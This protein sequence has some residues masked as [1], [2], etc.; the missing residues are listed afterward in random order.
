MTSTERI[1]LSEAHF[2]LGLLP[3]YV[4]RRAF[5]GYAVFGDPR[6]KCN[7]VRRSTTHRPSDAVIRN[8]QRVIDAVRNDFPR[9]AA[10]VTEFQVMRQIER[11]VENGRE[12]ELI[13]AVNAAKA[14]GFDRMAIAELAGNFAIQF[15]QMMRAIEMRKRT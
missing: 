11:A 6:I 14:A 13:A 10:R 4:S 3:E 15:R 12:K 2:A 8:S 7:A 5:I 9:L 1:L